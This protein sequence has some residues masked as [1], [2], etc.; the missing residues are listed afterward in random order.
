[1]L[2][3][4][5]TMMFLAIPFQQPDPPPDECP[6]IVQTALDLTRAGCE[7]TRLNQACYGHLVLDAQPRSGLEEFDFESPGDIVDVVMVQSLRLSAMDL[8]S[9]QWGVMLMEV[10]A[11]TREIVN[12]DVQLLLFGDV[13][14]SDASRFVMVR[15]DETVNIRSAPSMSSIVVGRL[16]AG[17]TIVTNSRLDDGSWLRVRLPDEASALGWIAAEFLTPL[18]DVDVLPALTLDEARAEVEDVR[19][20]YGP[21]QAFFF[22]SGSND[23]LCPEA[24]DSGMLIQT[25]EG[26]GEVSIW[27][28]EIVIQIDATAFVQ[29]EA[30]GDLAINVL[31]GSARVT[32]AGE[33]RT[34]VAGTQLTVPLNQELEAMGVPSDPRPLDTDAVSSLPVDLL[35]T[36]VSIPEPLSVQDGVPLPGQWLFEWGVESLTCPDGTVF[37]FESS[38]Q[39]GIIE[40]QDESLIWSGQ[41]YNQASQGVYTGSYVDG[42]GNLHRDTLRVIAGD[43]MEGEQIVDLVSPVC[44]LTAPFTLQLVSD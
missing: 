1:M 27:M 24:P 38:G 14:L 40:P 30:G 25:P 44:T 23:A 18:G 2:R 20:Q 31:D 19:A 17:E 21:M 3:F 6:L 4:L 29:A 39:P 15:A 16:D 26:V 12:E 35:D 34:V 28:D 22:R 13:E 43:R 36:A 8:D 41:R 10:E 42:N 33:T 37:P 32:A 7:G 9:G 11:S 5:I